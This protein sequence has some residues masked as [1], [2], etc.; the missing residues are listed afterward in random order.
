MIIKKY[1]NV[2][3]NEAYIFVMN[4]FIFTILLLNI[5]ET[6][7][8]NLS[9]NTRSSIIHHQ[10]SRLKANYTTSNI[11]DERKPVLIPIS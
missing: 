6:E 4:V 2:A 11:F 1:Q 7:F 10:G 5:D 8:F 9:V 3:K